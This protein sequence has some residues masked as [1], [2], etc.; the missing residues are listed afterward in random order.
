MIFEFRGF[1]SARL[2]SVSS[3]EHLRIKAWAG[4]VI[5]R[6]LLKFFC[7]HPNFYN[8]LVK[9]VSWIARSSF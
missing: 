9:V 2:S 4:F 6:W 7:E 1:V 8:L 5:L 3:L